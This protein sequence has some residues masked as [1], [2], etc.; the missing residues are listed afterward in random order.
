MGNRRWQTEL[1]QADPA[2]PFNT[3]AVR[4]EAQEHELSPNLHL[5]TDSP[6]KRLFDIVVSFLGLITLSPVL[7]VIGAVVRLQDGGPALYKGKRVG[8]DW[9]IFSLYKFRSMVLNADAMG[10]AVTVGGDARITRVGQFLRNTKLDELPQLF[11][12]LKGDMSFV[13]PRPE[14]PRYV[15]L[16]TREQRLLL[17]CR[18]GITSPA[19]LQYRSEETLLAGENSLERYQRE[20]LPSKL[21]IE[22]DYLKTRTF[23]SDINLILQT[24]RRLKP[25]ETTGRE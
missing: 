25:G 16:Y 4:E 13:G 17:A 6:A 15:V 18:P 20:I 14:D 11:N 9:R 22:L 19:S 3:H 10:P 2:A 8:K 24:I 23:W 12:V 21:S 1:P 5:T 7:L